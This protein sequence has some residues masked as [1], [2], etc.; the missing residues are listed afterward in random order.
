MLFFSTIVKAVVVG[1]FGVGIGYFLRRL[2]TLGQ[3]E[4]AEL[5]IKQL[6]LDAKTKTQAVIEEANKKAASILEEAKREEKTALQQVRKLEE[7]LLT[8]EELLEKRRFDIEKESR[9]MQ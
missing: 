7:K 1:L 6:L 9:V 4:S 2:I 3:K 5:K 8:K